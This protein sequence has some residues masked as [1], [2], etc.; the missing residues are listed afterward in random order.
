MMFARGAEAPRERPRLPF[1][2][3]TL[4]AERK[5]AA[6]LDVVWSLRHLRGLSRV[7]WGEASD[8][9]PAFIATLERAFTGLYDRYFRVDVRGWEHVSESPALLVGNHSGFGVAELLMLL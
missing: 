8:R 1:R 2:T 9:D 4:D 5:R 3:R 7:D 6:A